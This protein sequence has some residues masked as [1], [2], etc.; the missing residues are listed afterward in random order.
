MSGNKEDGAVI[1]PWSQ[2]PRVEAVPKTIRV[3]QAT[4]DQ[5]NSIRDWKMTFNDVIGRLLKVYKITHDMA[6]LLE[7]GDHLKE[8]PALGPRD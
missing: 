7:P 1:K 5:L 6:Q 2:T 3:S 8:K 4:W